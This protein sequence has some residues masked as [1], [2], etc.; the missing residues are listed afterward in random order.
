M[1][2]TYNRAVFSSQFRERGKKNF[3]TT[4]LFTTRRNCLKSHYLIMA[5]PNYALNKSPGTNW[6][7]EQ[8]SSAREFISPHWESMSPKICQIQ[9]PKYQ[10]SKLWLGPPSKIM[11]SWS[12]YQNSKIQLGQLSEISPSRASLNIQRSSLVSH[13]K[14][15]IP[16]QNIK[17]HRSI[18][19]GQPRVRLC[20]WNSFP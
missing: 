14:S 17:I 2:I 5:L 11:P 7:C 4:W 12:K 20:T 6:L 13:R 3:K 19:L 10:N 18:Q 1:E 9:W 8:L 16:D 15:S